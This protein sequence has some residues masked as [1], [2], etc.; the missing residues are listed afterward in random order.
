MSSGRPRIANSNDN[1]KFVERVALTAWSN[2]DGSV[3]FHCAGLSVI[4]EERRTLNGR[5]KGQ[6]PESTET[7]RC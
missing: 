7:K 2:H 4:P 5:R 6:Q 1:R 3:D